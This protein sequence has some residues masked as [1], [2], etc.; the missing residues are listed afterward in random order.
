MYVCMHVRMN[1]Y[2]YLYM[3]LYTCIYLLLWA[4]HIQGAQIIEDV[5]EEEE[6]ST[7]EKRDMHT[8]F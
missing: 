8:K 1:V 2:K 3:Y 5:M 6:G 7:H 4:K